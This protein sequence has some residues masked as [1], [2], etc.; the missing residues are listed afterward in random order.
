MKSISDFFYK[1]A[2]VGQAMTEY[3]IVVALLAIA[4]IAVYQFLGQTVRSQT[5]AIA[6]ELSGK[7]GA[8]NVVNAQQASGEATSDAVKVKNLET[9]VGGQKGSSD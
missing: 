3:I 2:Q 6:T 7:S 9:Y 5:A 4:S 1:S 8:A